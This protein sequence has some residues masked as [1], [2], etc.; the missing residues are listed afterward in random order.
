[1]FPARR[2][3]V[4]PLP[5]LVEAPAHP[6]AAAAPAL[7]AKGHPTSRLRFPL[8]SP[9]DITKRR[10]EILRLLYGLLRGERCS[11]QPRQRSTRCQPAAGGPAAHTRR[12][13]T[14]AAGDP[15]QTT[16]F[17]RRTSYLQIYLSRA[18]NYTRVTRVRNTSAHQNEP[19]V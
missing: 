5:A 14:A 7:L 8:Q 2:L 19:Q 12:N 4:F 16:H 18:V 10:S 1:M 3:G 15:S 13:T 11:R 17:V 9:P 6:P